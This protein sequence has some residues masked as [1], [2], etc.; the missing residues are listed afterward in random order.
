M[1]FIAGIGAAVVGAFSTAAAS[2]TGLTMAVGTAIVGAGV[3]ALYSA[4]TGG[5]I[6]EG[7]LY[8]AVGGAVVGYGASA[9]GFGS[10]AATNIAGGAATTA[11]EV[12]PYAAGS[13]QTLGSG[14]GILSGSGVQASNMAT[15][16][17]NF[18]GS[19][20]GV[21]NAAGAAMSMGSA[22]VQGGNSIDPDAAL[23]F[24][25]EEAQKD[26]DLKTSLADKNNAA[27]L[28]AAGMS[29]QA[30]RDKIASDEKLAAEELAFSKEKWSSEFDESNW[31][32]RDENER[33]DKA[34]EEQKT[35]ISNASQAVQQNTKTASLVDNFRRRK[36]FVNPSWK[37][38][39]AQ[40]QNNPGIVSAATQGAV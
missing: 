25:E 36:Q 28:E 39:T 15:G 12:A 6:L 32:Y 20:S 9:L 38:D 27:S 17:S 29:L 33:E 23:A 21:W 26:R 1:A 2:I 40:Q 3:G 31:R 35:A 24:K 8:G 37:T 16:A 14:A 11:T 13:G 7:A 18:W 5:N 22:F 10:A 34:E 4:V 30:T 19:G